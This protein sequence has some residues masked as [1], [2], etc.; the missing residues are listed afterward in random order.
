MIFCDSVKDNKCLDHNRSLELICFDCNTLLCKQC[1][2][3]HSDHT[4]THVDDIKESVT[5]DSYFSYIN[6]KLSDSSSQNSNSSSFSSGGSNSNNNSQTNLHSI[7]DNSSQTKNIGK[8]NRSK[9]NNVNI[10]INEMFDNLKNMSFIFHQ[11]QKTEDEISNHF[12]EIHEYLV[13]EE[14]RLKKPI[15]KDKDKLIIEIDILV[16]QLVSMNK[17]IE[18]INNSN[19][20]INSSQSNSSSQ[21]S[22]RSTQNSYNSQQN[23]DS[24]YTDTTNQYQIET[25]I[26][27]IQQSLDLN[28]FITRN[29]NS[30]FYV[31][32]RHNNKI[33][34]S[35]LDISIL[36]SIIKFNN[37]FKSMESSHQQLQT[38]SLKRLKLDS[39]K[40]QT[41]KTSI[42]KLF[43]LVN[44]SPDLYVFDGNYIFSVDRS[45][46][47][48]LISIPTGN[49]QVHKI[50]SIR[51][52]INDAWSYN[53]TVCVGKYIYSFGGAGLL[54]SNKYQRFSL[55]SMSID[56]SGTMTSIKPTT[57]ISA[58]YD[59][60]KYI[61]LLDGFG[62]E[63]TEVYR[64]DIETM[65]FECYSTLFLYGGCHELSF[66]Y[67]NQ[68]Y[69]VQTTGIRKID[70]FT[71]SCIE[72]PRLD[73]TQ[74]TKYIS[75]ESTAVC[76][77]GKGNIYT[78]SGSK[79]I[80][81][82]LN[83]NEIRELTPAKDLLMVDHRMIYTS[84]NY[85]YVLQ[86][87]FFNYR[88]SIDNDKWE[89]I[90][91]DDKSERYCRGL[92]LIT[93]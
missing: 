30:I 52:D 48:S 34:K 54:S 29:I 41:W 85:I 74:F 88:Y 91:Q 56:I 57:F 78:H 16:K 47:L 64:Y 90:L 8:R 46:R 39:K 49:N 9:F 84:N 37:T 92:A 35:T 7:C 58:C 44:V 40:L 83:T 10:S 15:I 17:I 62:K 69:T 87:L 61:Y 12:R 28:D 11:L 50:H 5:S 1:I 65:K 71:K 53:S 4:S 36:H 68:M 20:K 59:G 77:D 21:N 2:S 67:Q 24:N 79:F 32:L 22:S 80:V 33:D 86:G 45:N 76:E 75:M 3:N 42:N 93:I 38:K 89:S 43:Q 60:N 6:R 19:N 14:H 18:T 73:N 82:N 63:N 25:I 66:F 31:D 81:L 26:Q 72:L 23:D 70:P 13:I 27:T 55:E 51:G